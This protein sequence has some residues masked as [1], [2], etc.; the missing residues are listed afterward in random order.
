MMK[1]LLNTSSPS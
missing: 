1:N